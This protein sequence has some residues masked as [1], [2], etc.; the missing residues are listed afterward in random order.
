MITSEYKLLLVSLQRI[1]KQINNNKQKLLT[2][3]SK[4]MLKN[5]KNIKK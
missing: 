5:K 4:K 3:K 1:V 2:E